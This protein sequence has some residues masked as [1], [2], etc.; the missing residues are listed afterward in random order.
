MMESFVTFGSFFQ[1]LEN[2]EKFGLRVIALASY[3]WRHTK[4]D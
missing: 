2:L 3:N 4:P 1:W